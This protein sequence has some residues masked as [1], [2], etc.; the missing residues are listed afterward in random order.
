VD[1]HV[2]KDKKHKDKDR[3]KSKHHSEHRSHENDHKRSKKDKKH[4][5]HKKHR[6]ASSDEE[7]VNQSPTKRMKIEQRVEQTYVEAPIGKV[8]PINEM[9]SSS[10]SGGPKPSEADE[11]VAEN[12]LSQELEESSVCKAS[13]RRVHCPPYRG[14]GIDFSHYTR[15]MLDEMGQLPPTTKL[16]LFNKKPLLSIAKLKVREKV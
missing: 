16:S 4:K 10:S 12:P 11:V 6:H 13:P 7:V 14:V 15:L 2:K 9:T 8:T 5:S 3:K 1:N